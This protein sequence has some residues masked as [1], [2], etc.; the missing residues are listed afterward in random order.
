MK[1]ERIFERLVGVMNWAGDCGKDDNQL[2][3]TKLLTRIMKTSDDV[4]AFRESSTEYMNPLILQL[5]SSNEFIQIQTVWALSTI[6][7]DEWCQDTFL[8]GGGLSP[9][10]KLL[11]SEHPGLQIRVL[12]TLAKLVFND[13]AQERI[14]KAEIMV[15]RF[16]GLLQSNSRALQQMSIRN[17]LKFST[18]DRISRELFNSNVLL[19]IATL[20]SKN[21]ECCFRF[22]L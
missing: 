18:N 19:A 20:L 13:K 17:V 10:L 8:E 11:L 16:V 22:S 9:L 14:L 5:K 3:A 7:D 4:T 1:Q 15:L 6:L 21:G 12:Y 2:L